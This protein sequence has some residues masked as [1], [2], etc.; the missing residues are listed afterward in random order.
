MMTKLA[1]TREQLQQETV[2]FCHDCH[3]QL[4]ALV[5]EK[6]LASSYRTLERILSHPG[7]AKFVKWIFGRGGTFGHRMCNAR[8]R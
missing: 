1:K 3:G 4:H 2:M 7:F 5:N 8:R 6:E